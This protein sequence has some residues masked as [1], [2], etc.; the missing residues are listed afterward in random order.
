MNIVNRKITVPNKLFTYLSDG[1]VVVL[2]NTTNSTTNILECRT[3]P[4]DP[5]DHDCDET[6]FQGLGFVL[7]YNKVNING[8]DMVI[9]L[10]VEGNGE[11]CPCCY[12]ELWLAQGCWSSNF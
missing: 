8:Q 3:N 12:E 1:E 6:L 2:K 7:G 9:L 4:S 10:F 5:T 11:E